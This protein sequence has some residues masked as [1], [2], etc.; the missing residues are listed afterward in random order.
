MS[1][2]PLPIR[3]LTPVILLIFVSYASPE[4]AAFTVELTTEDFNATL[5]EIPSSAFALVEFFA[6]WCAS[7]SCSFVFSQLFSSSPVCTVG[8]RN[9]LKMTMT[10]TC[11]VCNLLW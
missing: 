7:I 1:V 10:S 2:N 9:G 8:V 6:P 3:W 5:A 11:L 4:K